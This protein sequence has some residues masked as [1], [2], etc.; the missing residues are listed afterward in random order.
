MLFGMPMNAFT[1]MGQQNNNLSGLLGVDRNNARN[2]G[3]LA[4]AGQLLEAGAGGMNPQDA[5]LGRAWDVR[6]LLA[7]VPTSK[8]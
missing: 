5:S 1:G 8:R 3:L 7:W 4:A 6:R 2:L